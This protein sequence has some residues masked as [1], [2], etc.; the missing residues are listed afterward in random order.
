MKEN[1]NAY[2]LFDVEIVM[3]PPS[4]ALCLPA[5]KDE[6]ER[7]LIVLLICYYLKRIFAC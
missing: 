3:R 2:L 4:A 6:F 5:E 1:D 7:L